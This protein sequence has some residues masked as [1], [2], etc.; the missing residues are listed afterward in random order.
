MHNLEFS[1]SDLQYAK[2]QEAAD[3]QSDLR[4]KYL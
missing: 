2:K 1:D 3:Y 4:I